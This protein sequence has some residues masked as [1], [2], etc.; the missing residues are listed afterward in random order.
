MTIRTTVLVSASITFATVSANAISLD[1]ANYC[2]QIAERAGG[3]Y[4]I[5]E[6]CLNQEAASKKR[7][8]EKEIP[9]NDFRKVF[10]KNTKEHGLIQVFVEKNSFEKIGPATAFWTLTKTTKPRT[11][12]LHK[13]ENDKPI[14]YNVEYYSTYEYIA[15]VCN[16]SSGSRAMNMLNSGTLSFATVYLD[17]KMKKVGK[18]EFQSNFSEAKDYQMVKDGPQNRPY[19][20]MYEDTWGSIGYLIACENS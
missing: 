1:S 15:V 2:R 16:K 4:Q 12:S 20:P 17:K 10:E 6:T 11:T 14:R 5:Y 9:S 13:W 3:S 18:Q 8:Q 7:T 19:N